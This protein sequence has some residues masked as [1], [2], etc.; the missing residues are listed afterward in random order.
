M[1]NKELQEATTTA[2]AKTREN[3]VVV[4]EL[5]FIARK[6]ENTAEQIKKLRSSVKKT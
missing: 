6:L 3:V 4:D 2:R 1:L 5:E